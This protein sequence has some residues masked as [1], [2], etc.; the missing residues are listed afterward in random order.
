MTLV[1]LLAA[2][3]AYRVVRRWVV[4]GHWFWKTRNWKLEAWPKSMGFGALNGH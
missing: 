3:G 2:L 1:Y 4:I